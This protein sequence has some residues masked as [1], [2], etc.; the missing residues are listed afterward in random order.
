[1]LVTLDCTLKHVDTQEDSDY[2]AGQDDYDDDDS[3]DN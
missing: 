3:S 2:H 1:M